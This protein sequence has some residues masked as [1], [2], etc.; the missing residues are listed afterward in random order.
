MLCLILLF[1][2]FDVLSIYSFVLFYFIVLFYCFI[3]LFLDCKGPILTLFG[4]RTGPAGAVSLHCSPIGRPG[5]SESKNKFDGPLLL[6]LPFLDHLHINGKN[7]FQRQANGVGLL[8]SLMPFNIEYLKE[9]A[10]TWPFP[11]SFTFTPSLEK[12][13]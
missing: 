5:E 7:Q 1:Y 9:F 8:S 12:R 2:T 10:Q 3:L 11:L 4:C 6:R 13:R